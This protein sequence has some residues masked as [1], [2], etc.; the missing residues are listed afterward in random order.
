MKREEAG[1]FSLKIILNSN[2]NKSNDCINNNKIII[3]LLVYT[4]CKSGC[5]IY[6]MYHS[7]NPQNN[8]IVIIFSDEEIEPR[9]G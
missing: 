2:D 4:S 8:P 3:E 9:R 5:F 1:S 7:F 6:Y